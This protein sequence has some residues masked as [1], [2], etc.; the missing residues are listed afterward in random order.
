MRQATLEPREAVNLLN[1]RIE[2]IS[3]TNSDIAD[4][5]SVSG[6]L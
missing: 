3:R 2:V 5:L 4:W 6:T 1:D